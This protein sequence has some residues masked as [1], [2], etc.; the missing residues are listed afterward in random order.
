[1]SIAWSLINILTLFARAVCL[2]LPYLQGREIVSVHDSEQEEPLVSGQVQEG[3]GDKEP[4]AT[5]EASGLPAEG[6]VGEA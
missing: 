6:G 3:G 5:E 2:H 4:P 1:M